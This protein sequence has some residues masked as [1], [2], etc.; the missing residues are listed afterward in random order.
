[1][2][3][4]E[5]VKAFLADEVHIRKVEFMQTLI[6]RHQVAIIDMIVRE[7]EK[8][9]RDHDEIARLHGQIDELDDLGSNFEVEQIDTTLAT[10]RSYNAVAP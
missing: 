1:M 8:S 2:A 4:P 3:D 5:K 7:E 9:A 6:A 10:F